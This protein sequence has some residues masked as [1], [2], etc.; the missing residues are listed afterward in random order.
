MKIDGFGKTTK[1]EIFKFEEEIGFKLPN[2]Y[3]EFL[4]NFNGGT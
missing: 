3:K 4:I 2:D 1:K